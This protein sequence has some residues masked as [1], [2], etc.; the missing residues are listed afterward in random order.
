M[1]ESIC[2]NSE[3]QQRRRQQEGIVSA[4][5]K[6]KKKILIVD[7]EDDIALTFK[8]ALEYDGGFDVDTFSQAELALTSFEAGVY[9]M[10]L[11][12]INM[13]VLN[14]FQLY[15]ELRTIDESVKICFMTASSEVWP[16]PLSLERS[17][18]LEYVIRKP[19]ES[20]ALIRRLK[21]QLDD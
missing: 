15:A 12:D 20:Q 11:L 6:L 17:E 16:T 9:D 7:D 4:E 5:Q 21:A 2:M 1:E 19:I 18:Y 3:Q 10:V 13:P 14:G 8:L